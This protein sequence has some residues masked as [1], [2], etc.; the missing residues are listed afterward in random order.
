MA[1]NIS[2]EVIKLARIIY[3]R[4]NYALITKRLIYPE[5]FQF[6]SSSVE[7]KRALLVSI[8]PSL[9]EAEKQRSLDSQLCEK[10]THCKVV[11]PRGRGAGGF[12]YLDTATGAL[13]EPEQYE[14]L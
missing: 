4:T 3:E 6:S 10:I 5:Q 14:K 2:E 11:K 7:G 1:E 9:T 12:E 8:S 13:V